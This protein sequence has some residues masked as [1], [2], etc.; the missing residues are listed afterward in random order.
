M[1]NYSTKK[2]FSS[3][4]QKRSSLSKYLYYASQ[5][6]FIPFFNSCESTV[7]REMQGLVDDK[8]SFEKTNFELKINL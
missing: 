7:S 8:W 4:A 1:W 2:L 3:T 6:D 5:V